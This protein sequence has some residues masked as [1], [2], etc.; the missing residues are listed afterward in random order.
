MFTYLA[1]L[2]ELPTQIFNV[3]V[4]ASLEEMSYNTSI[5]REE[6]SVSD[7]KASKARRTLQLGANASGDFKLKPIL[8]F[9]PDNSGVLKNYAKFILPVFYKWN[10]R[11][12]VMITQ[13]FVIWSTE[14]FKPTIET[15]CSEKN[16]LLKH[17]CS[18]T[19]Y[20]VILEL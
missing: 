17:Y 18:L 10:S 7:F 19:M 12:W 4:T 11:A 16:F 20:L 3:D 8:I 9:H 1:I 6:K 15:Y 13:L 5:A 2:T 14:Y